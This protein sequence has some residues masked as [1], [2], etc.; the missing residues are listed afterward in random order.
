MRTLGFT[1]SRKGLTQSQK[2]SFL[3]A[4]VMFTPDILRHGDCVG[5]DAWA[6]EFF[7]TCKQQNG[8][9]I[10]LIHP[11]NMPRLRAYC[12]G[13][14]VYDPKPPLERNHDIVDQCDG[15][16]ACPEGPEDRYPRSGTWATVRYA[17]RQ[18]KPVVIIYPSGEI[19]SPQAHLLQPEEGSRSSLLQ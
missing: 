8:R 9:P 12:Q 15:L 2:D 17:V 10:I 18:N 4:A 6:H 5:A 7:A 14:V 1:G 3:A 16:L 13:D 19:S 11:A